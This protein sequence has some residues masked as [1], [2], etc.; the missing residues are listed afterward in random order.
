MSESSLICDVRALLDKTDCHTE[1]LP[2]IPR[3]IAYH[4]VVY[5][6]ILTINIQQFTVIATSVLDGW[7]PIA[8]FENRCHTLAGTMRVYAG[9]NFT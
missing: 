4:P 1:L 5:S 7:R 9:K 8:R 3:L 6:V 2:K